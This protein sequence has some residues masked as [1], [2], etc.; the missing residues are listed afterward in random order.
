MQTPIRRWTRAV[1]VGMTVL[2]VGVLIGATV[3]PSARG[4]AFDGYFSESYQI[5]GDLIAEMERTYSDLYNRSAPGVVSIIAVMDENQF[6]NATGSGFVMDLE[7]HIATNFHV[8]EDA[9]RVEVNMYDGTRVRAEVIG[10][11]PDS[12]VAVLKV[13]VGADRLRPLAFADSDALTVGQ[14]V[15]A[16]GN[17]FSKDWTLTS[18]IIS[19]L[20]RSILGLNRYRIG[21]VI[22]TDAAINPG[23]SG[24]P[25]LNL[26]G[27]VIGINSQIEGGLRQNAGVGFAIP[28]NLVK[29]IAQELISE[30]RVQYS[31]LGIDSRE[32]NLDIIED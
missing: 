9:T 4:S 7:G 22:Q 5:T 24:G 12:D 2:V 10:T 1:M 25:L 23:N 29:R 17:P 11:D 13:D 3:W 26:K 20:N 19:A 6:D 14:V 31:F 32:L 16:I 8:V 21:G 30:G 15:L 28:S 18:G 27:E